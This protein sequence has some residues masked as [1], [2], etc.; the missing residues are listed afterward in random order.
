M[1]LTTVNTCTLLPNAHNWAS[2]PRF[3]LGYSSTVAGGLTGAEDRQAGMAVPLRSM[4]WKVTTCNPASSARLEVRIKA[5]LA[6]GRAA[7]PI[8]PRQQ[9][10]AG[11][12]TTT[13]TT[14]GAWPWAS[15]DYAFFSNTIN[16]EQI[17]ALINCG[18]AASGGWLADKWG[19]GDGETVTTEETIDLTGTALLPAPPQAVYQSAL[20]YSGETPGSTIYA[21]PN[22]QPGIHCRIRLHFAEIGAGFDRSCFMRLQ[23]I[24]VTGATVQTV[25]NYEP[26]AVADHALN[27]AVPLDF[28]A[29]PDAAGNITITIATARREVVAISLTHVANPAALTSLD[30][31]TLIAGDCYCLTNQND[32]VDN[33]VFIHGSYP[34][35]PTWANTELALNGLEFVVR[36]PAVHGGLWYRCTNSGTGWHI[37][38][39][40]I[41]I[42]ASGNTLHYHSTISAIQSYQHAW[43][44]VQL[45]AGTTTGSLVWTGG[46]LKGIY[47]SANVYPVIFGQLKA[48][49]IEHETNHVLQVDLTI[50]EPVGT[51]TQGTPGMCPV[52]ICD[53]TDWTELDAYYPALSAP[54]PADSI[55]ATSSS[56]VWALT[57]LLDWQRNHMIAAARYDFARQGGDLAK[58]IGY[59]IAPL[60]SGSW[61][62][63]GV[64]IGQEH[65]DFVYS[66]DSQASPTGGMGHIETGLLCTII[67]MP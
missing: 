18:G 33:G 35:R 32:M 49:K 13:A 34:Q 10:I 16:G 59:S 8:W 41:T 45:T 7:A 61:I 44:C 1:S 53:G 39:D 63:L 36:D 2:R 15:G 51:G 62:E 21:V 64:L 43:D 66:R 3:S 58:I 65:W 22:L 60:W 38:A 25:S 28:T 6:S 50:T 24:T 31:V 30:G 55:Q 11:A 23:D 67:Y 56:Y 14:S 12:V 47:D 19:T 40:A 17:D 46:W 37:G 52:E 20:N 29:L 42:Q 26:F 57:V 9:S 48:D 5:A 54:F 4:E 27:I